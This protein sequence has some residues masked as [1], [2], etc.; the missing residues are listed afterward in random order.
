MAALLP[1][2]PLI[3]A[4]ATAASAGVGIASA[5]GAFDQ[6][7]E[8]PPERSDEEVEEARR[9]ALLASSRRTGRQSTILASRN[10]DPILGSPVTL[11]GGAQPGG[12]QP[13]QRI[14]GG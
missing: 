9:R 7:P 5:A 2:A 13:A 1:F 11:G 8:S 10:R 4:G 3:A 6:E 12:P 14:L